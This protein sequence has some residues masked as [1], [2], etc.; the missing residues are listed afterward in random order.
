MHIDPSVKTGRSAD[1]HGSAAGWVNRPYGCRPTRA[2]AR[3]IPGYPGCLLAWT[4]RPAGTSHQELGMLWIRSIL[5]LCSAAW[6]LMTAGLARADVVDPA[7]ATCPPG[8][9][10]NVSHAGPYCAILHCPDSGVCWDGA[11]CQTLPLCIVQK[12]GL[13]M[14]GAF[15]VDHVQSACDA[16]GGCEQGQC[17]ELAVCP[18]SANGQVVS[19]ATGGGGANAGSTGGGGA[20]A[21]RAGSPGT[22]GSAGPAISP[23]GCNCQLP[24]PGDSRSCWL[25]LTGVS[26]VVAGRLRRRLEGR[27][28][29]QPRLKL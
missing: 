9:M 17:R 18:S 25:L 11:A 14:L 24:Q 1:A 4:R 22:A 15:S 20:N 10:P 16:D 23:S 28:G 8:G 29:W 6:L 2:V 12:T 27:R 3:R 13:S 7:P 19:L 26:M 21:V 5:G